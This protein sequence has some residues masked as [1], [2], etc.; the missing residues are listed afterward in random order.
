MEHTEKRILIVDDEPL[1][2]TAAINCLEDAGYNTDFLSSGEEAWERLSTQPNSYDAIIVDRIMPNLGGIDLLTKI[3]Q[4]PKLHD[5]PVIIETALEDRVD[6]IEALEAGAYD[7]IY[8]PFEKDFLLY[9][10]D[11]AV[12]EGEEKVH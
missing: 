5:I 11:S 2:I 6:Y 12:H 3:K 9:V 7:F 8:K 10:V 4:S 1:S